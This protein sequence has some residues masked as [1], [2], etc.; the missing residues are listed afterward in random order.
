MV[1]QATEK[2]YKELLKVK[3]ELNQ[4]YKRIDNCRDYLM[5]TSKISASD[6]LY[7]LGFTVNGLYERKRED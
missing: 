4:A 2:Y 1:K 7:H 5:S 3:S 6:A